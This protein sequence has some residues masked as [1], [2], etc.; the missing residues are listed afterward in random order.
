MHGSGGSVVAGL[1]EELGWSRGGQARLP[2]ASSSPGS[3]EH[4]EIGRAHDRFL[5]D[6]GWHWSDPRP[7]PAG[8]FAGVPADTA[9][10]TLA[11]ILARDLLPCRAWVVRDPRQGR[12][13]PLWEAAIDRSGV[14]VSFVHVLRHPLDVAASL[15]AREGLAVEHGLLL[16][17]R[18]HL[19]AEL[20]TRGRPRRW[21][22]FEDVVR[23]PGDVMRETCRDL[24]PALAGELG[25]RRAGEVVDPRLLCQQ[26]DRA[27]HAGGLRELPWLEE[28]W[29]AL[30]RVASGRETE[31]A[32]VLDGVRQDL[33]RHDRLVTGA[34]EMFLQ[35]R[36]DAMHAREGEAPLEAD[37][38]RGENDRLAR[39]LEQVRQDRERLE[40]EVASLRRDRERHAALV[41]RSLDL[42]AKAE[43]RTWPPGEAPAA[44]PGQPGAGSRARPAIRVPPGSDRPGTEEALARCRDALEAS[45]RRLREHQEALARSR[46]WR[47]TAV[48]RNLRRAITG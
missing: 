27:A 8:I 40:S 28:A 43:A 3:L 36:T 22:L 12:L 24:A 47:Y 19:E 39:T 42:V 20:A 33:A 17:V 2:G 5:A 35:R 31:G 13:L 34:M 25:S 7:V 21:L 4:V 29:D 23:A 26:T 11:A 6:T 32:A 48:L 46:S 30:G 45:E 9:R 16:W 10:R 37:R 41:A 38:L 15:Q 44:P 1:L 18:H 14:T